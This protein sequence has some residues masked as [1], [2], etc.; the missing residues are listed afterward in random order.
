M[1]NNNKIRIA[2][3]GRSIATRGVPLINASDI[4]HSEGV[5]QTADKIASH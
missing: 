3:L 4:T 2:V 1:N 5:D